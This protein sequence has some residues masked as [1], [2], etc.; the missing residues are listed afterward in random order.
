MGADESC[1]LNIRGIGCIKVT[2]V[3]G[4][5]TIED[6]CS[7]PT[8]D[9]CG[10]IA[11]MTKRM[12]DIELLQK[13]IN[14]TCCGGG[15]SGGGQGSG[16]DNGWGDTNVPSTIKVQESGMTPACGSTHTSVFTPDVVSKD[17]ARPGFQVDAATISALGRGGMHVSGTGTDTLT[18]SGTFECEDPSNQNH[19]GLQPPFK[20]NETF[21]FDIVYDGG[22]DGT[23]SITHS[24]TMAPSN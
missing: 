9:V 14:A 8:C 22:E 23:V 6:T 12:D 10:I 4:L 20:K 21:S 17:A 1:N 15:S 3:P 18:I 13:S 24:Y 11:D 2:T 7:T 19:I 16:G 5:I